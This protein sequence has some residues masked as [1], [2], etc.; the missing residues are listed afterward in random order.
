LASVIRDDEREPV[1]VTAPPQIPDGRRND[2]K[3][4]LILVPDEEGLPAPSSPALERMV[5]VFL[6]LNQYRVE[7]GAVLDGRR[8]PN[9]S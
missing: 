7:R 6:A 9:G 2:V 8:W 4:R 5:G 1:D 3:Y